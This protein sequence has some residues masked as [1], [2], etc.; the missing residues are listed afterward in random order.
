MPGPMLTVTIAGS[1]QK[2][3]WVGPLVVLGHGILELVLVFL[4]LAGLGPLLTRP[5]V[6]GSVGFAGGVVLWWLGLSMIRNAG[7]FSID[8]RNEDHRSSR[9]S[10][11]Y[12]IVSSLSNPYW[13]IWWATIG[14][15]YLAAALKFGTLGIILFFVGHI[16]ADL[17]WYSMVSLAVSRGRHFIR[18]TT[19]R[20]VIAFCGAFLVLFGAWFFYFGWNSF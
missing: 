8:L 3:F 2:G 13:S 10:I 9:S 6:I 15:G 20:R 12:G 18:D 14:M 19:Y 7:K 16:L 4:V 17:A 1:S 11:F 5:H